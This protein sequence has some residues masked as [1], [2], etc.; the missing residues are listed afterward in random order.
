ML[1]KG[2]KFDHLFW[3]AAQ[4]VAGK[5][6]VR[7]NR[8]GAP[9][10]VV[11]TG[12]GCSVTVTF[13][14]QDQPTLTPDQ[15]S[16]EARDLR[17]TLLAKYEAYIE[18]GWEALKGDEQTMKAAWAAMER[19]RKQGKRGPEARQRW[20]DTYRVLRFVSD[21]RAHRQRDE[22]RRAAFSEPLELGPALPNTGERLVVAGGTLYAFA[23]RAQKEAGELW[24]RVYAQEGERWA[25]LTD[26]PYW[27]WIREARPTRS[28]R[29]RS[30]R[31]EAARPSTHDIIEVLRS[32]L[33]G[34][35]VR[36]DPR[37]PVHGPAVLVVFE[38]AL[39]RLPEALRHP[40]PEAHFDGADAG[41]LWQRWFERYGCRPYA[42]G[43]NRAEFEVPGAHTE[44]FAEE[45][46]AVAASHQE[47]SRWRL[48]W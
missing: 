48:R 46:T 23:P 15:D 8:E 24:R 5:R 30:R 41:L 36:A 42:L 4:E 7:L 35:E 39:S 10:G 3:G 6:G 33:G 14:P 1:K 37:P 28:P 17:D 47:G 16:Q 25:L 22:A 45:L 31:T 13:D 29:G 26:L 20:A 2:T 27:E 32:R 44:A 21:M 11:R 40:G 38:G 18:L 34:R 9:G 43:A 19:E 12:A